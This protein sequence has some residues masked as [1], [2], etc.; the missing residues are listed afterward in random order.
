MNTGLEL[1]FEIHAE[2]DDFYIRRK[3]QEIANLEKEL[4]EYQEGQKKDPLLQVMDGPES[5]NDIGD[6]KR[7]IEF[8]SGK[9]SRKSFRDN[10]VMMGVFWSWKN[11][12]F[13]CKNHNIECPQW[14]IE[15]YCC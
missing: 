7:L 14:F 12:P 3:K 1:Y 11:V 6:R 9:L 2:E 8:F 15:K 5:I 13:L 10:F 4:R